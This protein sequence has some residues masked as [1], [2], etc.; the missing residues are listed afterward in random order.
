MPLNFALKN[1]LLNAGRCLR[2]NFAPA[3]LQ[4][5]LCRR[6]RTLPADGNY[7]VGKR[8]FVSVQKLIPAAPLC[9]DGIKPLN[10]KAKLLFALQAHNIIRAHLFKFQAVVVLGIFAVPGKGG[11]SGK[12]RHRPLPV[13]GLVVIGGKVC[14]N[15]ANKYPVFY[16]IASA[17]IPLGNNRIAPATGCIHLNIPPDPGIE[18]VGIRRLNI[19]LCLPAA[20][21]VCYIEGAKRMVGGY[22]AADIKSTRLCKRKIK[23]AG[24][25]TVVASVRKHDVQPSLPFLIGNNNLFIHEGKNFFRSLNLAQA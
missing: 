12:H 11:T 23:Q 14:P 21:T 18:A 13:F 8:L 16:L 6:K 20:R 9:Q 1:Q 22:L 4:T 10:G 5:V 17:V 24:R 3:L 7:I 25:N 19:Y 15:K 2:T